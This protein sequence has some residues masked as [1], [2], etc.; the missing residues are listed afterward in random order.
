MHIVHYCTA[1]AK[2]KIHFP[3]FVT[4]HDISYVSHQLLFTVLDYLPSSKAKLQLDVLYLNQIFILICTRY[5]DVI[6]NIVLYIIFEF[7]FN[8]YAFNKLKF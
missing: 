4:W 1:K 2:F 8:F 6:H 3:H 7:K 5:S